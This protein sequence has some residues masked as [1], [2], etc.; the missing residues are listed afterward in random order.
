LDLALYLHTHPQ[1][2]DTAPG[3]AFRL[4]R[5]VEEVQSALSRLLDYGL[6]EYLEA[7]GGRYRCYA[8]RKDPDMRSL[9]WQVSRAYFDEPAARKEIVRLITGSCRT[10]S[11]ADN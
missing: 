10:R 8:L 6:V 1:V 2:F 9:L 7:D 5:S 3:F 11:R 4:H